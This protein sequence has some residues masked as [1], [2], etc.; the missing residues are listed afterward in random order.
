LLP[1]PA[2]IP[3]K[4]STPPAPTCASP[5]PQGRPAHWRAA[6]T[7]NC[8]PHRGNWFLLKGEGHSFGPMLPASTG[9]VPLT[10]R[11][12][13]TAANASGT[14]EH[15]PWSWTR[16]G[17]RCDCSPHLRGWPYPPPVA[18]GRGFLLPAPAGMVPASSSL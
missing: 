3:T 10:S 11:P 6:L 7:A 2:G 13:I 16:A 9:M 8:F 1:A 18:G 17:T 4:T 14:R 12:R 5:H 15:G